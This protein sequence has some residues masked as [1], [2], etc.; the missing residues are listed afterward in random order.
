MNSKTFIESD[1]TVKNVSDNN[2]KIVYT[3]LEEYID[4]QLKSIPPEYYD[5]L[6]SLV[7]KLVRD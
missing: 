3:E 4:N 5:K 1:D 7:R 6:E 2:V